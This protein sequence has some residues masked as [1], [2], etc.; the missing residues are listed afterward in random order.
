MIRNIR[1]GDFL[2][3]LLVAA[4]V[5]VVLVRIFLQM[6]GYPQLGGGGL[7]IAHLLWGGAFMLLGALVFIS[8]IGSVAM[9]FA[10][11]I[12]GIGFGLYIDEIGKFI[13]S[14]NNYFFKPALA[15]I[16]LIFIG[17]YVLLLL[18]R[19]PRDYSPEELRLN[20]ALNGPAVRSGSFLERY[21]RFLHRPIIMK[22]V[23]GW[24]IAQSAFLVIETIIVIVAYRLNVPA[25]V[26]FGG[27]PILSVLAYAV[28]L[29]SAVIVV[30]GAIRLFSNRAAAMKL[31]MAAVL[32]NLLVLQL[33]EFY[34]NQL[35]GLFAC[36]FNLLSYL[37]IRNNRLKLK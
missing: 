35:L 12:T 1:A 28:S 7:H 9:R 19:R 25:V 6:F 34:Q 22:V 20:V 27:D 3:I 32:I 17:L 2:E 5:T 21:T 33:M 37:V 8:F 14:D 31:F 15:M 16:Y 10:A 4:A 23:I 29:L 36:I 30:C 11:V 24:L 18:L 26:D 13:T